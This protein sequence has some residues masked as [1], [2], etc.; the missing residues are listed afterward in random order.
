[1][2]RLFT[3]I[4]MMLVISSA[5]E[6]KKISGTVKCGK[7][8]LSNVIVTDGTSFTKTKANGSFKM[9]ISD[10]ADYVYV[11]TP[12][13]YVG[14][15]SEGSPKFYI[16]ASSDKFNFQLQKWGDDKGNYSIV[17]IADPQ[18]QSKKH[19]NLFVGEP[20][21]D[22]AATCKQQS[23]KTTTVGLTLGDIAWDSGTTIFPQYKQEI[24][25][26]GIPFYNVMGNHDYQ[27]EMKGD[28]ETSNQFREFFGPENY[29]FGVGD[30]YVIVLDDII[31]DTEKKYVEGFSDEV[32]AWVENLVA[33]IPKTSKLYIAVHCPV[34]R[35]FKDEFY[36]FQG[37][38]L[39][40]ILSEYDVTVLS[41]HTHINYNIKYSDHFMEQNIASLCGTW[42]IADHCNDGTPGGYKVLEKNNGN[43]SWYYKSVGHDKDYQVE[44][45][46]PGESLLH[47]N[48]V[49]ANIWDYDSRWT[50]EWYE[51]GKLKGDMKQVKGLSPVFQKEL[52]LVYPDGKDIPSYKQPRE[53]I[54][55]FIA[56]PNQYAKKVTVVIKN[57]FGKEWKYDVD[58]T[59][60]VDVQ[61]HRGGAGLM[62]ENTLLSMKNA[63]DLGV[64]TLELDLQVSKDDKVVVSHDPYFH[65]RYSTRPDGTEV[66]ESDPKEYLYQMN[67]SDIKKYD[68]GMKK[69]TVWPNKT[70]LP[71]YKPLADELINFAEK[72]AKDHN[73]TAPRYNI[74]IKSKA[75]DGEGT[76]WPDYKEFVD[77]CMKCLLSHNLGDRLVVQSFDARALN[78]LHENYPG[79]KLSYLTNT[80]DTD[81]DTYMPLLT[82]TPDWLSPNLA[83][84]D[85]ALVERCH[86]KGI[87]IVP[88][89]VDDEND[90]K[91]LIDLGC[92]SIIS[93]YPDK[94]LKVTRGY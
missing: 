81:W 49:V 64:N 89:T 24:Q 11:V 59:S 43:L 70:C 76:Q 75:G 46:K 44:I 92:D 17:A 25:R 69:T 8:K 29:A 7:E 35:W 12:A 13:G 28:H 82:F 52:D 61:A 62:P 20:L 57:P 1:M 15:W 68:V 87:K 86:S 54:H 30:D 85:A 26:T 84:V 21:D 9:N 40:D 88:W 77:K 19:F 56:E 94:L 16:P 73:M 79:V 48:A 50:V 5:S 2:K 80:K 39:I 6:A 91:K 53:N 67:Y 60:Y 65:A 45:Y 41:G 71:A 55:Y 90:M 10:N 27:K 22:L 36:T 14:D 47:P 34:L 72:Y 74:E 93:N 42:W 32:L 51:D 78:Y 58:M 4:A 63:L 66:Q 38:K 18:T 83:N 33:F 23:S 37:E 31:Y 3:A